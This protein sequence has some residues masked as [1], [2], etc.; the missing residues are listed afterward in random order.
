MGASSSSFA[1]EIQSSV[2]A[3]TAVSDLTSLVA[4]F[5]GASAKEKQTVRAKHLKSTG[6]ETVL[7]HLE[8][9][10][11]KAKSYCA[12]A[13]KAQFS[14]APTGTDSGVVLNYSSSKDLQNVISRIET[15]FSNWGITLS[16]DTLQGLA[17]AIAPNVTAHLGK[18]DSSFGSFAVDS[19]T[20][21]NWAVAHG[22]FAQTDDGELALV[23]A[24]SAA[25]VG[26]FGKKLAA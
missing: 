20:V 21:I 11:T 7:Q 24:F 4:D 13:F 5:I 15:N 23:F 6:H 17:S 14:A 8:D 22:T 26:G 19:N 1:Q 3:T 12:G 9:A 16:S 2:T 25:K 10:M 18:V